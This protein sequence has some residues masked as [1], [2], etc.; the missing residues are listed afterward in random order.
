M[1][2]LT[3]AANVFILK[4]REDKRVLQMFQRHSWNQ[5]LC[6]AG[7]MFHVKCNPT[8]TINKYVCEQMVFSLK[9]FI[10]ALDK[11]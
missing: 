11:T 7:I 8:E 1:V 6:G 3:S 5:E 10:W 9:S 4:E 2:K